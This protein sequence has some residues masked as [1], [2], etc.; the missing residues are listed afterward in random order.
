MKIDDLERE[1]LKSTSICIEEVKPGQIGEIITHDQDHL[2]MI[3]EL[4]EVIR[5]IC[6]REEVVFGSREQVRER[7]ATRTVSGKFLTFACCANLSYL[8]NIRQ[9]FPNHRLSPYIKI[10]FEQVGK[11]SIER[12]IN[13]RDW[14]R[15]SSVNKANFEFLNALVQAIRSDARAKSF[16]KLRDGFRRRAAKNRR[17]LRLYANK[18]FEVYSRILVLRIDFGY[19]HDVYAGTRIC[20]QSNMAVSRVVT[21]RNKLIEDI[22]KRYKNSFIG[23]VWKL[24]YGLRKGFHYHF[25]LMLDGSKVREDITI[26]K[27]IGEYWR[28]CVTKGE[29]L[30]FN[31]NASVARY[32]KC[33][34]GMVSHFDQIKRDGLDAAMKYLTKP[35]FYIQASLPSRARTLGKGVMP[36]VSKHRRGAPRRRICVD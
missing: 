7:R 18:M 15:Y 10:Y 22:K 14:G 28:I 17:S 6:D 27:D 25:V 31:C 9:T 23:Y 2:I 8:D 19:R 36:D 16:K 12:Q 26:A 30:Y 20:F 3:A 24:E 32:R 11:L 35:D 1:I 29:G 13:D 5:E 4:D 21:D 34:I 33:G